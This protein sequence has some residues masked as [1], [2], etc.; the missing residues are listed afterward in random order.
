MRPASAVA[1]IS[2]GFLNYAR[3]RQ[4]T[5]LSVPAYPAGEE[6]DRPNQTA[7]MEMTLCIY[8]NTPLESGCSARE[9]SSWWSFDL[10]FS[11]AFFPSSRVEK[12]AC[13]NMIC[14]W[15]S[16]PYECLELAAFPFPGFAAFCS[17]SPVWHWQ[18]LTTSVLTNISRDRGRTKWNQQSNLSLS[19]PIMAWN[20]KRRQSERIRRNGA[21]PL[22]FAFHSSPSPAA[23]AW[24]ALWEIC[25][26]P[27]LLR[28][29]WIPIW[30]KARRFFRVYHT[31]RLQWFLE[32]AYII[33]RKCS[34]NPSKQEH[35]VATLTST[36]CADVNTRETHNNATFSPTTQTTTHKENPVL[37]STSPSWTPPSL[38]EHKSWTQQLKGSC[39]RKHRVLT[40]VF[41]WE[42]GKDRALEGGVKHLN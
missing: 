39:D 32:S 13:L 35:K 27:H 25:D 37:L 42:D 11:G 16:L 15:N 23:S 10:C 20:M 2:E 7:L 41:R 5:G 24:V 12:S 21:G 26:P 40:C 14:F 19:S 3:R 30:H 38:K 4:Q 28:L 9:R 33:D 6:A 34:H 18:P 22:P 1:G 17:G 31:S 8:A 36:L 29:C